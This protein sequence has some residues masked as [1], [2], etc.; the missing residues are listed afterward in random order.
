VC[1]VLF[2][3]RAAANR[4]A[5]GGEGRGED[6]RRFLLCMGTWTQTTKA[7]DEHTNN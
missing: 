3:L 1:R 2:G 6:V 7:E 4:V 5:A